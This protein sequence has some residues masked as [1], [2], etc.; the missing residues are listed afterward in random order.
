MKL[1]HALIGKLPHKYA[2]DAARLGDER[3][4]AWSNLGYWKN[5]TDYKNAC[6][7][8]ADQLAKA[9]QLTA[10]DRLLDLG[11][12]Q[13]ASLQHWIENYHVQNISAVEI[14]ANHIQL[15]QQKLPQLQHI[16]RGSF[17]DLNQFYF[18]Q[19][20]DVILCI[21]AAYHSDLN[22][23]LNAVQPILNGQGR[24]GFHYLVLS[25]KWQQLSVLQKQKYNYLLKAADVDLHQL[26]SLQMTRQQLEQHGFRQIEIVDLTEFVLGGFAGFIASNKSKKN[27]DLAQLKIQTTAKLCDYLNKEG[28]VRYM[29]ISAVKN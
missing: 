28:V 8:L 3:T 19:L 6:C 13:G 14:Q 25:E 23:F 7:Q 9:V 15:I 21:D 29:Q 4:L 16:Q 22:L 2:I 20:F 26:D 1:L 10:T 24:L 17:L 11:C 18:R 5:T 27:R 12:G